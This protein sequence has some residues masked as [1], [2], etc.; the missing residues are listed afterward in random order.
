MNKIIFSIAFLML[1]FT[2]IFVKAQEVKTYTQTMDSLLASVDKK[3][4]KTSIL[5]DRIFPF[6][7]LKNKKDT[8]DFEYFR[9]AYSELY[10]ASYTTIF[11]SHN[12]V[13]AEV[14][15]GKSKS[16][17][18]TLG[19]ID[20][21]FDY[22]NEK[23]IEIKDDITVIKS[24]TDLFLQHNITL[25]AP[26]KKWVASTSRIIYAL[27]SE[28]IILENDRKIKR[29]EVS[30][31]NGQNIVWIKNGE[32]Q[33]ENVE[34]NYET[35][36]NKFVMFQITFDDGTLFTQTA[37]IDVR[38]YSTNTTQRLNSYRTEIDFIG[39][40]GIVNTIPFKGY[41]ETY[42]RSGTLEYRIYYNLQNNNGTRESKITKPIIVLDGFDPGDIR[43]IYEDSEGYLR[44]NSSIYE[45]MKFNVSLTQT[46]NLVDSLRSETLGYDVILVNFPEGADYIER[47][48]MA[49]I[50]LLE[51]VN[52][53]LRDNGSDEGIVMIGPSMGGLIS[54]YAL[55]YM[56]KRGMNHNTRLWISFDSPHWGANIPL[57]AQAKLYFFGYLGEREAAKESF[58]TNFRSPAARQMLIE[59]LDYAHERPY[60][61]REIPQYP[62]N[63]F[64]DRETAGQNNNSPFRIRWMKT[65]E[66]AGFPTNS[67]K[68]ALVNG[69][70]LSTKVG[71]VEGDTFL[72]LK[73]YF[74]DLFF[75]LPT[76]KVIDTRS[77]FMEI[78]FRENELFN[79]FLRLGVGNALRESLNRTNINPRGCMDV[80]Q[81][82]TYNTAE[83]IKE[84]FTRTLNES[85]NFVAYHEW[86]NE[87][88]L[89]SFIPTVSSLAFYNPNFNWNDNINRN[90]IC[91]EEIPFDSYF[92]PNTNEEH[93]YVT[94][95]SVEWLL[96]E[97]EGNPQA[98]IYP[99]EES[100]FVFSAA[101]SSICIGNEA[102]LA[103]AGD[104][105]RFS[106]RISW[107]VSN[108]LE[109]ASEY[110][111]SIE[112]E[113][114][115]SGEAFITATFENGQS[116][117]KTFWVGEPRLDP[118]VECDN[119]Q[120]G[121][122]SLCKSNSYTVGNEV[123]INTIST[124]NQNVIE[125]EW[126]KITTNFNW[127][128]DENTAYFQTP[129][130]GFVAFRVRA[131]NK[132]GWSE[133]QLM[134]MDVR[135]CTD[136]P[137][138][139][140]ENLF[141]IYPNPTSYLFN[142]E[143]ENPKNAM[144]INQI[145][146]GIYDLIG[147]L[148]K[149]IKLTGFKGQIHVNDLPKGLYI[150]KI[151]INGQLETHQVQID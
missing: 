37:N 133:W 139:R 71:G 75:L 28:Y 146:I 149:T 7:N 96:E 95:K 142:I 88:Y 47:N 49:V 21:S 129:Q 118:L 38:L 111:F 9:Q 65:I 39:D 90:L 76:T 131:R 6:A 53:Q 64:R 61:L 105:C 115:A 72:A 123:R 114:I 23:N 127:I 4:M 119:N 85:G 1:L 40:S 140:T 69:T 66:E 35:S 67:R 98:P 52:G 57:G 104:E 143:L 73:G 24:T 94:A 87:I 31:N 97:I 16:N 14:N 2:S 126:E 102:N 30:F 130:L 135:E 13:Y 134:Q 42:A 25:I 44:D 148:R 81:G 82:G 15:K 50:A 109:I 43:K 132:C 80:V 19:I 45:L 11:K 136:N 99:F 124:L 58:D 12:E 93:V 3:D 112:T 151:N 46:K 100:N 125:W 117:T 120:D 34:V 83:I 77:R 128:T 141:K 121:C 147:Q 60:I 144:W 55:T 150:L 122:W 8:A 36:G 59:Q 138:F 63:L 54:R 79:G 41:N 68:I 27:P 106:S 92:V 89:H 107:S 86:S 56:E 74:V 116:Y 48:A 18:V 51:R 62:T 33:V 110:D 29:L 70:S 26:L 113:A 91:T 20:A 108:N 103:A 145:E 32:K 137:E 22:L 17:V 10:R 78:P 5:Y 84:E 101:S